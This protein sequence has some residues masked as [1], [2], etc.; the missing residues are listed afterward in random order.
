MKI[1]HNADHKQPKIIFKGG[2]GH[3]AQLLNPAALAD[4][5]MQALPARHTL[6]EV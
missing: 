2:R 5:P 3:P 6:A 1:T 4:A